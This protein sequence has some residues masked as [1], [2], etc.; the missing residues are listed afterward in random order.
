MKYSKISNET[1]RAFIEKVNQGACTIRQA[2]KQFGIKFS[3][4]KAILSL[5][6]HEGRVGKKERRTR[7]LKQQKEELIQQNYN[8]SKEIP[9]VETKQVQEFQTLQ[10]NE[11]YNNSYYTQYSNYQ[12]WYQTQAWLQYMSCHNLV[13]YY[14]YGKIF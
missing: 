10:N 3:T 1:R 4:G 11:S 6:K 8:N 7:R 14:N 9:I 2:A 12:N 13:N 5:Y